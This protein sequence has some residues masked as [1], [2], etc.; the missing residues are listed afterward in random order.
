MNGGCNLS[1][2]HAKAVL[3]CKWLIGGVSVHFPSLEK[4]VPVY[5]SRVKEAVNVKLESPSSDHQSD[6]IH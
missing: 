3:Y 2:R 5:T 4:A 1:G 6:Y